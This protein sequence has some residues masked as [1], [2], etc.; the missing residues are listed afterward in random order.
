VFAR[1]RLGERELSVAHIERKKGEM[2]RD[3]KLA[4]AETPEVKPLA[5][6]VGVEQ[7]VACLA[8]CMSQWHAPAAAARVCRAVLIHGP[9]GCGKTTLLRSFVQ[10]KDC[11]ASFVD[12]SDRSLDLV[13]ACRRAKLKSATQGAPLLFIVDSL[14]ELIATRV[15]TPEVLLACIDELHDSPVVL[16]GTSRQTPE[17]FEEGM[18]FAF[19]AT[20]S[21]GYLDHDQRSALLLDLLEEDITRGTVSGGTIS[22]L[23]R[24]CQGMSPKDVV[25]IIAKAQRTAR[26]SGEVRSV[27]PDDLESARKNHLRRR[28]LQAAEEGYAFSMGGGF[29]AEAPSARL[30]VGFRPEVKAFREKVLSVFGACDRGGDIGRAS[31]GL[32][33]LMS[34]P[35]RNRKDEFIAAMS[36]A[37]HASLYTLDLASQNPSQLLE[38]VLTDAA[39]RE[40]SIIHITQGEFLSRPEFSRIK[41]QIL[42]VHSANVLV[43]ISSRTRKAFPADVLAQGRHIRIGRPLP[44]QR[45]ELFEMLFEH[46]AAIIHDELRSVSVVE[47]LVTETKGLQSGDFFTLFER[48]KKCALLEGATTVER[49]HISSEIGVLKSIYCCDTDSESDGE[50]AASGGA[51]AAQ[52]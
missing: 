51:A 52:A 16:V 11:L 7:G 38:T 1:M 25:A 2:L 47:A 43:I 14:D 35:E 13:A 44:V 46:N 3:R 39:S 41:E 17:F 24:A 42:C 26:A 4:L 27:L 20:V 15:V 10:E 30:S 6:L 8:E 23:S 36:E 45:R 40:R 19:D 21:C 18:G 50:P 32:L 48:A 31:E 29:R 37:V 49:S 34:G 33:L 28:T 12:V 5:T 9:S 22:E